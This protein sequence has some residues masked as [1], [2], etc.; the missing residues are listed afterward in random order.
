[1]ID[2]NGQI[3]TK[4]IVLL[5]VTLAVMS[6]LNNYGIIIALISFI[7]IAYYL[8]KKGASQDKLIKFAG[9]AILGL[10]LVGSLN[11]V[12]D[13]RESTDLSY[14]TVFK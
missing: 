4:L 7:V 8:M 14:D 6:G 5:A 3:D 1:M 10:L 11:F 2:K 9:L 12:Y 13:V